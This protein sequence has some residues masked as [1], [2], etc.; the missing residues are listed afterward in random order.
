M[1][2][3]TPKGNNLEGED[4]VIALLEKIKDASNGPKQ[5]ERRIRELDK[6]VHRLKTTRQV[7]QQAI[8]DDEAMIK[9]IEKEIDAI[10]TRLRPLK[11]SYN[12]KCARRD[13]LRKQLDEVSRTCKSMMGRMN[14]RVRSTRKSRCTV[15]AADALRALESA[16]K[17][18]NTCFKLKISDTSRL[19]LAKVKAM[20][21]RSRNKS[22]KQ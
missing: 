16:R 2:T 10:N 13:H 12:E 3:I 15:A 18:P 7:C 19:Y 1:A 8:L 21:K 11:K 5:V 9:K 17:S 20:K 22:I 6:T 14:K 4:D